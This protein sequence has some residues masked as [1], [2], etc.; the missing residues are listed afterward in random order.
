MKA[1]KEPS[2]GLGASILLSSGAQDFDPSS[3][4]EVPTDLHPAESTPNPPPLVVLTLQPPAGANLQVAGLL[5]NYSASTGVFTCQFNCLVNFAMKLTRLGI[6]SE[7]SKFVT[8]EI[9]AGDVEIDWEFEG[10][11]LE[12]VA[13]N[14]IIGSMADVVVSFV[15]PSR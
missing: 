14:G 3:M 15:K 4:V 1:K 8:C 11:L 2:I 7:P 12:S 13:V 5:Q 9:K 10:Y 6:A